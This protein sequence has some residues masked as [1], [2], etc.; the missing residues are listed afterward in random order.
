MS[1]VPPQAPSRI[2]GSSTQPRMHPHATSEP[3]TPLSALHS[4]VCTRMLPLAPLSALHSR[5]CIRMLPLAPL[6]APQSHVCTRMLP[7]NLSHPC[8]LCTATVSYTHLRAHETGAY[9]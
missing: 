9:L 3:L 5:V 1:C 8:Q 7:L 6:S 2:P 4:H